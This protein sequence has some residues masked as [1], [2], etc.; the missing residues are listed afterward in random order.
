MALFT[1]REGLA[2]AVTIMTNALLD[3]SIDPPLTPHEGVRILQG[4]AE[5]QSAL[6]QLGNRDV[7]AVE[8]RPAREA[9]LRASA[10]FV[11]A[12]ADAHPTLPPP[13]LYNAAEIMD[14]ASGSII[15]GEKV[16]GADG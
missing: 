13:K 8:E 11:G 16:F 4:I 6:Y 9:S 5:C 15:D 7:L 12:V 14:N 1:M 3:P 10:H 2:R